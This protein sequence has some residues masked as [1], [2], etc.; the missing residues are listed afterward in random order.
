MENAA[1]TGE[2]DSVVENDPNDDVIFFHNDG[3][4]LD[5]A[6]R[7]SYTTHRSLNA[8]ACLYDTDSSTDD[9]D[10]EFELNCRPKSAM[11]FYD[12]NQPRLYG[13]PFD[14]EYYELPPIERVQIG[15]ETL[16]NSDLK[17][18]GV[19]CNLIDFIATVKPNLDVPPLDFE[20]ILFDENCNP[21]G[22]IFEVFGLVCE[23]MYAL[24]FNSRS[25]AEVCR[26]GMKLFYAPNNHELTKTV[27]QNQ[28][29]RG[30]NS[31]GDASEFS[32]DETER[33]HKQKK[34]TKN[35]TFPSDSPQTGKRPRSSLNKE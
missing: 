32:D 8:I 23:P 16:K 21:I 22:P 9:S 19:V 1:E 11:S 20:T 12:D 10:F 7:S 27:Y 4:Q 3:D 30:N 15:T 24:R 6:K 17:E 18:L 31:D 13:R 34:R 28:L 29:G 25:E 26:Q 2:V 33:S 14:L 35:R 5:F